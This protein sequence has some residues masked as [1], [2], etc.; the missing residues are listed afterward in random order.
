MVLVPPGIDIVD[1][2]QQALL[3]RVRSELPS[4]G[5]EILESSLTE[6]ETHVTDRLERHALATDASGEEDVEDRAEIYLM[7]LAADREAARSVRD[8]LFAEG[9][10]VRLPPT[11]DEAYTA[12]H[13]RRLETADAF[14][15]FWGSADESWLEPLLTE[16]KRAKG[17]RKGKPILS[18][19]VYLADPPTSD[20]HDYL[21]RQAT[22]VHGFA[23]TPV[24]EAVR[25]LLAELRRAGPGSVV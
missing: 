22:L 1:H 19:A 8:C 9:F 23:P 6:I 5:F 24:Q 16:L 25:P 18:K 17:L 7:C 14:V 11:T 12:L 4:K 2:R 13:T 15:I 21:T 10:E 20:K 3:E